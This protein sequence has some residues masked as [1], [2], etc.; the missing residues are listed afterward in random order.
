MDQ[1]N[2][3]TLLGLK[4]LQYEWQIRSIE[5]GRTALTSDEDYRELRALH[6]NLDRIYGL[7]MWLEMN[8]TTKGK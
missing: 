2:T 8:Q 1:I 4:R 6:L 3:V 7:I 5:L